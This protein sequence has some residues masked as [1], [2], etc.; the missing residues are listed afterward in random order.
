MIRQEQGAD[1]TF[2]PHTLAL[3]RHRALPMR[4]TRRFCTGHPPNLLIYFTDYRVQRVLPFS[5]ITGSPSHYA[6]TN[7]N[8]GRFILQ[9]QVHLETALSSTVDP[10]C[11]SFQDSASLVTG[12]RMC[13]EPRSILRILRW[14]LVLAV[15]IFCFSSGN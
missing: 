5:I 15:R 7:R 6:L 12:K 14:R 10:G 3:C 11:S 1:E 2:N 8:T 9:W 13:R 4:R